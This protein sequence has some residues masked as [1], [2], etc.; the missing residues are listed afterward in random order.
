MDEKSL[1]ILE[2]PQIREILAGYTSF[3]VGRELVLD[4]EPLTD[5]NE[6]S[7]RLRQSAEARFLLSTEPGF[8]TGGAFDVREAVGLAA[9]GRV[10]E[11]VKLVEVQQTLATLRRVRNHLSGVNQDVPLL[12]AIARDIADFGA[13]EKEIERCISPGG[14]VLDRASARCSRPTSRPGGVRSPARSGGYRSGPRRL[15]SGSR[16]DSRHFRRRSGVSCARRGPG[17]SRR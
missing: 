12:W 14:E 10:L 15:S 3:S 7:L 8:D 6:V 17:S 13:V 11:P 16:R 2:F 5:Y 1:E 4:L 9:L